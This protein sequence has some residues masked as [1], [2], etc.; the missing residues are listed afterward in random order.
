MD[1]GSIEDVALKGTFE[2]FIA[3][4]N[5]GRSVRSLE[6]GRGLEEGHGLEEGRGLEYALSLGVLWSVSFHGGLSWVRH[7]ED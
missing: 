2:A 1:G 5:S 3:V 4:G 7:V 6:E